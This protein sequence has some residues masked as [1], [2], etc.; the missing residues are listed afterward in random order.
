[1]GASLASIN[2]E[3]AEAAAIK[4]QEQRTSYTERSAERGIQL[5]RS[6]TLATSDTAAQATLREARLASLDAE[7][8]ELQK[9][10]GDMMNGSSNSSECGEDNAAYPDQK[11]DES[12][13]KECMSLPPEEDFMSIALARR[14]ASGGG[15]VRASSAGSL[16]GMRRS[17]LAKTK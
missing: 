9:R 1:M 8:K 3:E 14:R 15:M 16:H 17:P 4:A 6:L 7:T 2:V 11:G 12:P 13:A 10:W 5:R